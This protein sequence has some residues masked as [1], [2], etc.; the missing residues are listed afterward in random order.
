[1]SNNNQQEQQYPFRAAETEDVER[2]MLIISQAKAQMK[3]LGSHQWQEG[4]PATEDILNDINKQRGFVLCSDNKVIAYASISFNSEPAYN[5]LNG[6][7]LSDQDYVVVHRM[8][9]ADE[10]KKRG[11][12]TYFFK[13]AESYATTHNVHSFRVD[14][15]FDNHYML[16]LLKTAGFTLCGEVYYDRGR[17]SRMAFEKL[18]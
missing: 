4:Y 14:T 16:S 17:G 6:K 7:W 1:M 5:E 3:K 13:C 12:A 11:I 15:N 9:V 2:I 18:I 8:A 10:M